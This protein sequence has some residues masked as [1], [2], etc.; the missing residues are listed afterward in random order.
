MEHSPDDRAPVSFL[1][2]PHDDN[3]LG[4]HS[5]R[6]GIH[7]MGSSDLTTRWPCAPSCW[8]TLPA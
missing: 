7:A 3:Q 5:D 6:L 1:S 2:S 8:T 4:P